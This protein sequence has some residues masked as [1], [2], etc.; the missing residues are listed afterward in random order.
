MAVNLSNIKDIIKNNKKLLGIG[1]FMVLYVLFWMWYFEERNVGLRE[2]NLNKGSK[3]GVVFSQEKIGI[4]KENKKEFSE[5][6]LGSFWLEINTKKVKV[7]APVVDGIEPEDLDRGLGRHRTMALPG[8]EGNM[9]ISGHRWKFGSNPAYKIF[10]DLDKLKNGDKVLVH[11]GSELFEYEIYSKGVV[12]L[13][14]KG[15]REV[16]KETDEPVLTLYTCTPKYTAL[17]R[18]YYRAKFIG[19]IK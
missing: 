11:Y 13:N 16:L 3:E 10:E 18:L 7:K 12:K 1:L 6:D 5:K 4:E 15:V 9:V 8:E 17:R 14:K 2:N 19:K